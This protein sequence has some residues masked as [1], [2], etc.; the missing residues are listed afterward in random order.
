MSRFDTAEM[1][2]T[3]HI[4]CYTK[5]FV[6]IFFFFLC[7]VSTTAE[8]PCTSGASC[9]KGVPLELCVSEWGV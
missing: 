3:E 1:R 7:T 9:H 5:G 2:E 4:T 8:V 6:H